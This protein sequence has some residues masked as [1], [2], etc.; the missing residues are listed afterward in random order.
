MKMTKLKI[1]NKGKEEEITK[2]LPEVL[3]TR[4][5]I[6]GGNIIYTSE[7]KDFFKDDPEILY[8]HGE[9]KLKDN[10]LLAAYF[11]E[12][13]KE[14]EDADNDNIDDAHVWKIFNN[15]EY[16]YNEETKEHNI[17]E[18]PYMAPVD[19]LNEIQSLVEKN[20]KI[21]PELTKTLNAILEKLK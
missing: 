4:M 16:V 15:Y 3:Y 14:M 17:E 10:P 1:K 8:T 13:Q 2:S 11:W 19:E 21:D 18:I 7:D 6:D 12:M 20:E 9:I 5:D